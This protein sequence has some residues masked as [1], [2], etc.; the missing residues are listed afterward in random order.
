[1]GRVIPFKKKKPTKILGYR[2][3]FYTEAEIELALL[4]LNMYGF[5]LLRYTRENLKAVD[6]IYIRNCLLRLKIS[7]FCSS[8]TKLLIN[9][10]IGNIEEVRNYA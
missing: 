6:P 9:F 4:A 2:M 8:E 3:S 5:Q 1:M 10:V 7:N